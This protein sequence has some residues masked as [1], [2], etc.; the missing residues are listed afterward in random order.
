MK[1]Q[2]PLQTNVKS[3]RTYKVPM[4]ERLKGTTPNEI[5]AESMYYDGLMSKFFDWS[6]EELK[7]RWPGLTLQKQDFEDCFQDSFEKLIIEGCK[8][9]ARA[10]SPEMLFGYLWA[11]FKSYVC[12]KWKLKGNSIACIVD[13]D[14]LIAPSGYDPDTDPGNLCITIDNLIQKKKIFT[15]KEFTFWNVYKV[16]PDQKSVIMLKL[17][18]TSQ[19][20]YTLKSRVFFKLNSMDLHNSL[21]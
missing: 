6:R 18:I 21:Y 5:F 17:N 7:K 14:R 19:N 1:K 10:T 12:K 16:Y 20:Y 13:E 3:F 8:G 9:K 4:P 2:Y 11:I 15:K